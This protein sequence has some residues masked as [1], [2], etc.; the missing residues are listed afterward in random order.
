MIRPRGETD[1]AILRN[2]NLESVQRLR[3]RITPNKSASVAESYSRLG[4][5]QTDFVVDCISQSLLAAQVSL[6]RL[7]AHMT[8]QELDLLKLPTSF[9]TQACTGPTQIV[10]SNIVDATF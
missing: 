7:H 3:W 10:W 8:E 2:G 1:I 9:M 4:W 5:F 6:C